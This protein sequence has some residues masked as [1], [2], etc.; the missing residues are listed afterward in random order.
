MSHYAKCTQTDYGLMLANIETALRDL[1]VAEVT[2]HDIMGLRDQWRE[3]PRTANKYQAL[4]SVLM[5]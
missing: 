2:S 5:S 3:K 1:D 4:V